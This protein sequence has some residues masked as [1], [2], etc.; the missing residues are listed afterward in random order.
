MFK[1]LFSPSAESIRESLNIERKDSSH[2]LVKTATTQD[3]WDQGFRLLQNHYAA[4]DKQ[5]KVS[6]YFCTY[7]HTL[8]SSKI[9]VAKDGN[10]VVGVLSLFQDSAAG[11]PCESGTHGVIKVL[12]GLD[13]K[14]MEIG[15]LFVLPKYRGA[16]HAISFSLLKYAYEYG[17]RFCDASLIVASVPKKQS[18]WYKALF[19]AQVR[20]D[21]SEVTTSK[22]ATNELLC[23][24]IKR[25][26]DWAKST[27][28][29]FSPEKNLH[30][31]MV[32]EKG[33]CEFPQISKS[34]D[35][36]MDP[37]LFEEF[38]IKKM[39]VLKTATP[40]QIITLREAYRFYYNLDDLNFFRSIDGQRES[41][42]FSL[43]AM[44]TLLSAG[45]HIAKGKIFDISKTGAFVET[46]DPID[47]AQEQALVFPWKGRMIA[48][49]ALPMWK[50]NGQNKNYPKGYGL[51]FLSFDEVLTAFLEVKGADANPDVD[52]PKPSNPNTGN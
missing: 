34:S 16:G 22:H 41:Q 1:N 7:F 27:Y 38:F 5:A 14:I 44:A 2:F 32:M 43:N 3:E 47:L 52:A 8:P 33:N 10:K 30:S 19:N 13:H 25:F 28:G 12:R 26:K 36:V 45:E 21:L 29:S 18:I 46:E 42:R 9:I 35:W 15:D 4:F 48:L 31:Y 49:R 17:T 40:Q 6:E 11:L 37:A 20:D 50:N 39:G 24:D 23:L 51:K